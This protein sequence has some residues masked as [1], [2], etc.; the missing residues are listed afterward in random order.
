MKESQ[1]KTVA[2]VERAFSILEA[3]KTGDVFLPL[4]ELSKRTGLYKSTILRLIQTLENSG[5]IARNSL[6]EYHIGPSVL[7]LS[8]LYQ[9]AMKPE[10]IIMPALRN[11]VAETNESAGFHIRFGDKRLCLYRVDS[12]HPLRDHFKPGDALPLNRGAGGRVLSAFTQPYMAEFSSLRRRLVISASGEIAPDM[13]GVACPV[14]GSSGEVF[15]ALTLSGPTTRFNKK[16]VQHFEDVMLA[17]GRHITE[18]MGGDTKPFDEVAQRRKAGG[19]KA[20]R[21]QER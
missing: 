20:K 19:T 12:P 1:V 11:L 2:A 10:E 15:G 7:R 21:Q 5:Y 8:R 3:F 9:A 17:A 6:G 13:G 18:A 14:F 4:A 16:S